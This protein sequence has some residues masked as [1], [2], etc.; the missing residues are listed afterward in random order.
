MIKAVSLRRNFG[1]TEVL[2]DVSFLF[3]DRGLIGIRG[4]SGAGKSTLLNIL[5]GLDQD[6]EG[7]L[8]C[9]GLDYRTLSK[10][11]LGFHRLR[12]VGF[13]R[14]N[15]A[16]LDLETAIDNVLLPHV[17]C[18]R[19]GKFQR[20]KALDLLR[21]VGLEGKEKKAVRLLSGGERARVAL[22]RALVNDPP[23]LLCDEPTA[24]LN[25][26]AAENVFD[27]LSSY[28]KKA[29]VIVVSHD[30][31]LLHHYCD[32]VYHLH[33]GRMEGPDKGEGK[34]EAKDLPIRDKSFR[35]VPSVPFSFWLRHAFHLLREKGKR[36]LLT[37]SVLSLSLISIL[38]SFYLKVSLQKEVGKAFSSLIG[39]KSLV[40]EKSNPD[41]PTIGRVIS[42]PLQEVKSLVEDMPAIF[43]D[44]GITY[45]ADFENFFPDRHEAYIPHKGGKLIIPGLSLRTANDYLYLEE[46]YS[47]APEKPESLENDQI[48]LGLPYAD[49]ANLCYGLRI[50]RS[51]ESLGD[52]IEE[53]GLQ[54]VYRMENRSWTYEDEQI[55]SI[56]AVTHSE[57]ATIYHDS[58]EWST[59]LYETKMRLPSKDEPD[60]SLPWYIQKV[61]YVVPRKEEDFLRALKGDL[62]KGFS[63]IPV[64]SDYEKT[65]CFIGETCPL[66]RYYVYYVDERVLGENAIEKAAEAPYLKSFHT[67]TD[68][69]YVSFPEAYMS[70]F[71]MPFY[72]SSLPSSIDGIIDAAGYVKKDLAYA[73]I[74]LPPYSAV[75]S[76][77]RPAAS[78]V[79]FSSSYGP[80]LFG[81][82]PNSL[83]EIAISKPLYEQ[84]GSPETLLIAATLGE[85]ETGEYLSRD[86]R[87][88][89]L[90]ISG[91]YES[92]FMS[93][94]H[95]ERWT[96]DFFLSR[97]K[98]NGLLLRPTK[99]VCEL[100]EGREEEAIASLV[101]L[102]P[103][104][105]L[106]VP[107]KS[108]EASL[109]SLS[110][111][112]S[113]FLGLL[114]G[115]CYA[116]SL[117]LLLSSG[118]LFSVERGREVGLL[119]EL[120]LSPFDVSASGVM[121]GVLTLSVAFLVSVAS[122]FILQYFLSFVIASSFGAPSSFAYDPSFLPLVIPFLAFGLLAFYLA[123]RFF[124]NKAR[125]FNLWPRGSKSHGKENPRRHCP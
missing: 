41:E 84:L 58:R 111:L 56:L 116:F 61:P 22:A 71:A 67:C 114:A 91:V 82:P 90:K 2:K 11:D 54:L 39:P 33:D 32:E 9:F 124:K 85:R 3:P 68:G 113:S 31:G 1:A 93:L 46:V 98:M 80:F 64:S 79:T 36:S 95:Y 75:G 37:L 97:L 35:K 115:I 103:G 120:G 122:S 125:P 8:S 112:L 76:Y 107:Y 50:L 43:S 117:L 106:S 88:Y 104:L 87:R 94:G 28:G 15:H 24:A 57:V 83:D 40:V 29:L 48:V 13:F 30:Q 10:K 70:G 73:E 45:L 7:Q 55:L 119:S 12:E 72:V 52:Y 66:N 86:I 38:A 77:L 60:Q 19:G 109:S 26:E 89:S 4:V 20:Q 99:L 63:F 25:K 105:T 6:Y 69:S 110:T 44:Y 17:A 16:L 81:K 78:S 65:H 59:Y 27:L 42:A 101:S 100:E 5:G 74:D 96:E 92:Q 102:F 34:G 18:N 14:Q 123:T 21:L 62:L 47:A 121:I 49:M 118:F 23:L 53:N 51:Y 108:M